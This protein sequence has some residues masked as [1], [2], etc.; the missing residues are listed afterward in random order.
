MPAPLAAA[1]ARQQL[2]PR[3]SLRVGD[4]SAELG[5]RSRGSLTGSRV[6]GALGRIFVEERSETCPTFASGVVSSCTNRSILPSP[7]T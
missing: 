6:A 4:V 7:R 3:V 5:K 1:A 2:L